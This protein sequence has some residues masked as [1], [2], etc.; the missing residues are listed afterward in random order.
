MFLVRLR[1]GRWAW[2][3]LT[4]GAPAL[5]RPPWPAAE[6]CWRAAAEAACMRSPMQWLRLH[7]AAHAAAAA[8]M[9]CLVALRGWQAAQA[10]VRRRTQQRGARVV[11]QAGVTWCLD[12]I[13]ELY[14]DAASGQVFE[15][16]AVKQMC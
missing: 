7:G 11:G 15:E 13:L 6:R 12:P 14:F 3:L 10:Q 9:R 1:V 16:S 5:R 2:C 8:C 4:A